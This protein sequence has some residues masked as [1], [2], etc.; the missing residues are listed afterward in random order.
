M[1]A[2]PRRLP[3]KRAVRKA[4]QSAAATYDDAAFLE[5]EVVNR[6]F[7]RLEYIKLKPKR[8]ADVGCR[9]GY[10]TRKLAAHYAESEIIAID[11]APAMLSMAQSKHPWWKRKLP[12]LQMSSQHCLCADAE[13]LPI[14]NTSIDFVWSN[15]ALQWCDP[16]R[17]TTEAYRVLSTGGLFMFTTLGP[18]T[19]KELRS[20]FS[21]IDAYEHVNQFIDMHDIGDT[22][23]HAGFAD[24]VMD[25]EVITVTFDD[26]RAMVR[27]L[28]SLGATN[29][30]LGRNPGLTTPRRWQKVNEHYDAF[31]QNG[32]LPVTIEVV[33]GHA[34]K[35]QPKS[36]ED[37]RQIIQFRDFPRRRNL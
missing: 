19:L 28:K 21:G 30:L 23:V 15:L 33:Y 35:P 7:E 13:S 12:F 26:L 31:R 17:S 29:H 20:A 9:T 2:D 18:D 6:M 36:L 1:S 10:G 5:R 4:L 25:M 37:G 8:I 22:L 32:K 34:W 24:P 27:D 3:D 11:T 14:A 16:L